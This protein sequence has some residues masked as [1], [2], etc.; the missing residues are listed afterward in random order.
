MKARVVKHIP[1]IEYVDAKIVNDVDRKN[2]AALV[3]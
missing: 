1:Q 2:A 3:E